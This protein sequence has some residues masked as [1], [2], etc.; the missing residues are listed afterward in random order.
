MEVGHDEN[1]GAERGGLCLRRQPRQCDQGVVIWG[2]TQAIVDI[3]DVN[4]V[5]VY[6]QRVESKLFS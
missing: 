3:P 1:T 4:D 6:P 5:M 2:L